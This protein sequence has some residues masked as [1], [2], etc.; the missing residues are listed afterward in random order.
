MQRR[1]NRLG[2]TV[3]WSQR[4]PQGKARARRQTRIKH[5]GKRMDARKD[6]RKNSHSYEVPQRH[7]HLQ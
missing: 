3:L 2:K 7:V 5:C 4:Y 1:M 6:G